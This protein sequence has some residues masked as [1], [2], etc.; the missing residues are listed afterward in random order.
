MDKAIL[1]KPGIRKTVFLATLNILLL[2]SVQ[3][4]AQSDPPG[5]FTAGALGNSGASE[6]A[7]VIG[8]T[9]LLFIKVL[10]EDGLQQTF[11]V[12]ESGSITHPL[13]GRVKLGGQTVFEAEA[14]IQKMLTGDYILNP[15]VNI[16]VMEHS[17]FSII[18]EVR[19]PGNYE[20]L[21][22]LSLMEGLSIAGGFTPLANQKKVKVLRHDDSGEKTMIVN[23]K[24][25]LNGKTDDG[26]FDIQPGDVIEVPQSIF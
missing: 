24:D 14:L 13:L 18:G 11:R 9:N 6:K 4:G 23:V 25:I 7:Y 3:A 20:I 5:N 21:G 1:R 15:N 8:P 2:F 12:D 10:G 17:R 26:R 19:K 22:H 16:F